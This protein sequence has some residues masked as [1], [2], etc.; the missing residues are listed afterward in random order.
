M[1]PRLKVLGQSMA[2]CFFQKRYIEEED[3][4]D[5]LIP[6]CQFND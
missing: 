4:N 5:D 2:F 3:D 6:L 1:N